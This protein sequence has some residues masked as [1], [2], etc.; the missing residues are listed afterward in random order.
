MKWEELTKT[1][2]IKKTF[3]LNGLCKYISVLWGIICDQT[4]ANFE[5]LNTHFI[6][7]DSGL[8]GKEKHFKNN[9]L[10]V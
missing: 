9:C 5:C 2:I 7:N 6:S 3:S 1:F 8:I 10:A 4:F